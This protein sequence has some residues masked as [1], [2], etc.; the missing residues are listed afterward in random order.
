MSLLSRVKHVFRMCGEALSIT[1]HERLDGMEQR[2]ADTDNALLQAS[3]RLA[4]RLDMMEQRRA[5]TDNALLQA[6]VRLAERVRE[7]ARYSVVET[8]EAELLDPGLALALWLY[9][10]LPS[11]K[12][13]VAGEHAQALLAPIAE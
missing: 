9:S 13:G 8:Q 7:S 1:V 12:A 10:H 5:D 3:V 6:S 2:R 4:E 11:R